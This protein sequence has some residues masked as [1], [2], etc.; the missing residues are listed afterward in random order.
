VFDID[1]ET[2]DYCGGAVKIIACIEDAAVIKKILTH[3]ECGI[4]EQGA[5]PPSRAPPR[6]SGEL[7][8]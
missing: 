3:R 2:C 8:D 6:G 1:I 7:F 4:S 5:S